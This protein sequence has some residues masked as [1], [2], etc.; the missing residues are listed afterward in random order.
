MNVK[1]LALG[2]LLLGA[3]TNVETALIIQHAAASDDPMTCELEDDGDL[4]H[5]EIFVDVARQSTMSFFLRVKN[6]LQGGTLQFGSDENPDDFQITNKVTPLRFDLRWE[7]DTTGFA[8]DLGDMY[9][10]QF[11]ATEPFCVGSD[12]RSFSGFDVIP[13]SGNTIE[14]GGDVALVKIRPITVQLMDAFADVFRLAG[15]AQECCNSA[16]ACND[17]ALQQ[18]PMGPGTPCGILQAEFDKIAGENRL[19]AQSFADIQKFRP[20]AI[21]DFNQSGEIAGYP[22]RLRGVLEGVTSD[23]TVVRSDEWWIIVN[24]CANCGRISECTDR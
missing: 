6:M 1:Y 19:N 7:C 5:P 15:Q 20:F 13:A 2:A 22:L 18:A 23:E 10:P 12:T 14:P 9:V 24:I 21:Y 4:Y 8:D 16:G 11:S 3:C 17:Q